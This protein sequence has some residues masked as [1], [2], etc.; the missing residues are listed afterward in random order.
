MISNFIQL[1]E[2]TD[3]EFNL[4][5]DI[6]YNESGISLTEHKKALMQSRL[7]RRLRALKLNDFREYYN[8]LQNNYDNELVN[9]LNSI[10]TNKTDFFREDK[11][12]DFLF[13]TAL[14]EFDKKRNKKIKIWS[15]GCSTGQ[16]PY[17]IAMTIL[18]YYDFHKLP[19]PD[20]K[21][22]A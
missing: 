4:F 21:I 1:K 11:H 8:Y 5:R 3:N 10:T 13:S 16:E 14:P 17:S 19:V 6:I 22:L 12:F 18:D 15:A 20:I 2:I 9:L 7:M